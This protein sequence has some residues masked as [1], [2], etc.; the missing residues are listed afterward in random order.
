MYTDRCNLCTPDELGYTSLVEEPP[1]MGIKEL[2][3][4]LGRRVDLAFFGNQPT[5]ITKN[6]EP[7]AV[8]IPYAWYEEI[9]LPA[10]QARAA[11]R[12]EAAG[13]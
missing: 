13:N 7:R 2:R 11:E 1:V 5:V 10:L 12:G 8:L 3:P 6:E 4:D 9:V